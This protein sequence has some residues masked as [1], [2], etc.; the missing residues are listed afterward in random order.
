M[1]RF[2]FRSVGL[3]VLL[4]IVLSF[5]AGAVRKEL[6]LTLAGTAFL[7]AWAYCLVMTL[8]LA[9][10]HKRR[11]PDFFASIDPPE[12]N[13]GEEVRLG[14]GRGRFPGLPGVLI[15][16]RLVLETGDGRFIRHD[17]DPAA[18]TGG[19]SLAV[20]KRGAYFSGCDEFAV[21][22]ALGFFRFAWLIPR[23]EECRLLVRPRA[24]AAAPFVKAPPGGARRR[25]DPNFQRGDNLID[26]RPYVPGDDPRRINWKLYGHGGEL[27]VRQGEP[28]PPPRSNIFIFIDTQADGSLF[29]AE[30]AADAVD[31]LCENALSSGLAFFDSGMDVQA[32]WTGETKI[33][34]AS[35]RAE[36]AA[37]LA[38]PAALPLPFTGDPARP[39][40]LFPAKPPAGQAM[41]RKYGG[42]ERYV[43]FE[44]P[45]PEVPADRGILIFALPRAWTESSALDRFLKNAAN[46]GR[47]SKQTIE[48]LFLY[49][50]EWMKGDA[51]R[52]GGNI[53][54]AAVTCVSLYS[55][56]EGIR[57]GRF[58]LPATDCRPDHE[59]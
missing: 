25:P 43:Q 45:L 2:R 56:R 19:D 29:S 48:L 57:A 9:L 1:K 8:L 55:R 47:N 46:R 28:E 20:K 38:L 18:R 17:F 34:G 12:I 6:V 30:L 53:E 32:G 36:L 11:A 13:A 22:D 27:F 21:F 10:I 31:L 35:G 39:G 50:G 14:F 41:M 3:F 4:L 40:A 44:P 59:P 15:R 16:C 24:A 51:A 23:H 5:I 52:S 37:V 58:K 49:S 26:H 54:A 42:R 7:A 33:R